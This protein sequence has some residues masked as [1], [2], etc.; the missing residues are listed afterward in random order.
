[1][2]HKAEHLLTTAAFQSSYPPSP[3]PHIHYKIIFVTNDLVLRHLIKSV[4]VLFND[5]WATFS[6]TKT[7]KLQSSWRCNKQFFS[8][9]RRAGMAESALLL[10]HPSKV[11]YLA[12]DAQRVKKRRS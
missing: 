8:G 10:L 2:Q 9:V 4:A 7:P 1:M 12:P 6:A 5:I 11:G 3:A